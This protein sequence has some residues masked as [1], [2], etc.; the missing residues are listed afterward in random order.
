MRYWLTNPWVLA[1]LIGAAIA[2]P[3]AVSN[4]KSSS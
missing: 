3:I 4:N 1:C 2:I